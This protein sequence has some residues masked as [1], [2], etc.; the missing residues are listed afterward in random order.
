MLFESK[1][2]G[3]PCVGQAVD[4]RFTWSSF[5]KAN[6]NIWPEVQERLPSLLSVLCSPGIWSASGRFPLCPEWTV[7]EPKVVFRLR[8]AAQVGV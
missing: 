4:L 1:F 5:S 3:V 6:V 7:N 8:G 2:Q